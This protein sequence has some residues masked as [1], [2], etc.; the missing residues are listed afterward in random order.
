MIEKKINDLIIKT[1]GERLSKKELFDGN[2]IKVFEEEY[3]LPNGK[4]VVKESVVKN[5]NKD[6]VIVIAK[7]VDDKYIL[8]FQNR[9]DNIVSVEFPSGYVEN[10]EDI[11]FAAKREVLEETGYSIDS[12]KLVDTFIPNIGTECSKIHIAYAIC[13]N[14]V[15]SQ[16]LDSD[17]FINFDLFS[18]DEV[19]YMIKNN[20]IISGGNKLAFYHLKELINEKEH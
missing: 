3:K 7:T 10:E 4:N 18:F 6:A 12:I 13:S 1:K 5:N 2:F 15:Q 14:K 8:V 11:L 19:E 9:I 16:S 17:E 20:Y